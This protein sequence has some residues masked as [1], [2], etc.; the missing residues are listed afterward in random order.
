MKKVTFILAV[1]F[2]AACSS[3]KVEEKCCADSTKKDSVVIPLDT[4]KLVDSTIVADTIK[5]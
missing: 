5:K 4:T 1:G 3:P 2:I